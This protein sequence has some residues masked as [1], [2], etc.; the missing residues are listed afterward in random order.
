MASVNKVI[1][2]GNLGKDPKIYK[3][4]ASGTSMALISV[5]TS[6]KY[7]G[8]DGNLVEQTE[9]H[10]VTA[11]GRQA[12]II[13]DYMRKGSSIYLEG[14]LQTREFTDKQGEKRWSTSVIV[15]NFQMIGRPG[16]DS[17]ANPPPQNRT[18][19]ATAATDDEE[20]PF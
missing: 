3:S 5:A 2:L 16:K 18:Q 15:E 19:S 9:W 20:V 4:E 10:N 8:K 12:E 13:N 17:A 11:Y 7:K 6:R 1:L 14:R